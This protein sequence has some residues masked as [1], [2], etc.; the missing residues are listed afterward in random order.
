MRIELLHIEDCPN[1]AKALE[2]VE[3]A[4]AA[5]GRED[6]SVH[7]RHIKSPADTVG[8]GFAGSPTITA[9]GS[10]IF[11]DGAPS[12]DLA[13][14]IYPTPAG[15]TGVPTVDQVIKALTNHGL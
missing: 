12:S 7:M 15:H 5:L 10:D 9:N 11:P 4:L 3:A 13:C 14:R 2:Q 8:T 1:T 6:V